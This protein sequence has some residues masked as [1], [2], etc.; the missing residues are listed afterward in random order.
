MMVKLVALRGDPDVEAF[1]EDKHKELLTC[2]VPLDAR[3]GLAP[4]APDGTTEAEARES[5]LK[6]KLKNHSSD[7]HER[8]KLFKGLS[9]TLRKY[10]DKYEKP[11][12]SEG[13][14][15]AMEAL[16]EGGPLE[17]P[18]ICHRLAAGL[19]GTRFENLRIAKVKDGVY[20]L[21]PKLQV[22]VQADLEGGALL[23]HGHFDEHGVL[24]PARVPV[25]A[26]LEEFG[27]RPASDD[28]DL[29]G[30]GGG[31]GGIVAPTAGV[32]EHKSG[33][34]GEE[35]VAKKHRELPPG[36]SKRESRSKP[37]VFYYVNESTGASQFERPV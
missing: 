16:K 29:F 20:Q 36:W 37:G 23:I 22:A 3:T 9:K 12:D 30:G 1:L 32:S 11:A 21:G 18:L 8:R 17:G 15:S 6:R 10:S 25:R 33:L 31:G 14:L 13:A 7:S 2:A 34:P 24:H 28:C 19:A 4:A 5:W 35:Q 27:A 26:F